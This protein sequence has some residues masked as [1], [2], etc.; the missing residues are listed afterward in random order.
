MKPL[1]GAGAASHAAG[2]ATITDEEFANFIA[3][4]VHAKYPHI[5]VTMVRN[6]KGKDGLSTMISSGDFPDFPFDSGIRSR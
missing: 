4:P 5:T 3:G 1:T 2:R 6:T